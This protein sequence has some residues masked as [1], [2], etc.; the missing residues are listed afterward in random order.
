MEIC[1]DYDNFQ[2]HAF[3]SRKVMFLI[4][5]ITSHLGKSYATQHDLVLG[6]INEMLFEGKGKFNKEFRVK[7]GRYFDL[8]VPVEDG[9]RRF[10]VVELKV[11]TS[12]LKYLRDELNKRE[13]VFSNSDY[14]YFSYLLQVG[15]KEEGKII[16]DRGCIYYL[17]II[18]IS[19]QT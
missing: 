3:W 16:K 10:E 14:L 2:I 8:K 17:V 13:N 15:S 9:K 18:K 12:Q 4:S 7:G 5:K 6:F 19:K 11:R 1:N